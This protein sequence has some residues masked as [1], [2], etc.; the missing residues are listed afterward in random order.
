MELRPKSHTWYRMV[1]RGPNFITALKW[2]LGMRHVPAIFCVALRVLQPCFEPALA[3][4]IRGHC[5][6]SLNLVAWV[7][8][9][10]LAAERMH[11][12]IWCIRLW[13]YYKLGILQAFD[14]VGCSCCKNM[15]PIWHPRASG[16]ADLRSPN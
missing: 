6:G 10:S 1:L 5:R 8:L 2:T 12:T 7:L 13:R 14:I 16:L 4:E 9:Q 15:S 11:S 3:S